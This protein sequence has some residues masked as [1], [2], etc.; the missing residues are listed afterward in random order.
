VASSS[1]TYEGRLQGVS[2]GHAVGFCWAPASPEERVRIAIAVDD[3]LVAE[4]MADIS[5]PALAPYGDGAHGFL[6]A[7]PESLQAPGRRRVLAL[8]GSEQIPITVTPSFWHEADSGNGWSDVVF[9]P[10]SPP[11]SDSLPA[12]VPEPPRSSD[13]RAVLSDG[14]LFDAREFAA[15][16]TPAAADLEA[17]VARLTSTTLACANVGLSYVPVVVPAK[18]HVLA[19]TPWIDR[20]WAAEL[21]ARLRDVDEVDLLDLL[22][23]LRHAARYGA[24][25][26]RTDADWN[27]RGGFF[28]ARA[29]VKEARKW[30]PELR[31]LALERLHLRPT[32][33]YRGTLADARLFASSEGQL[34]RCKA[35]VEAEAGVVLDAS[36]L[37]ALRM[38]VES[39]L[40]DA[41]D[42]ATHIRV[43]AS[44][45]LED[46]TRLALVGDSAALSLTPWLAECAR[47]TT[48]FW[49]P[50]PPLHQLELELPSVVF[51]LI[52]EAD[53][54]G[55][56]PE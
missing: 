28:V 44:S 41:G 55:I 21:R 3:E 35:Q 40:A 43:Y 51:H 32:S 20:R 34:V 15:N 24:T 33:G 1:P 53:L 27:D 36:H 7:L 45:E 19:S 30:A 29:L 22:P 52:R 9:E 2:N 50:T 39:H 18:R 4:G 8:A 38:P 56:T 13:L 49:S 10:G 46:D 16:S 23:V 26:Q 54:L 25:Y 42:G 12:V 11:P 6:I 14:W 37:N 48:F 17:V 5:R 31:P 47:R